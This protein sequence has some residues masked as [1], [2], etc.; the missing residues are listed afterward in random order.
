MNF[1]SPLF[2]FFLLVFLL[3]RWVLFPIFLIL[4]DSISSFFSK[5]QDSARWFDFLKKESW[6]ANPI[7]VVILLAGSYLFY[8]SWNCKFLALLIFTS[9]SDFLIGKKIYQSEEDRKRKIF[10]ILSISLNL[11]ILGFFKY[12][13]FFSQNVSDISSILG[14]TMSRPSWSI[15][16]PAGISFYTF[17]SLSYT[18]D[19]YR[20]VLPAEKNFFR[21]ALFLAFFPQLVAGPIVVAYDFLPQILTIYKKKFAEI[22]FNQAFYFILLG[23]IKKSVIADNISI[24]SDFVFSNPDQVKVLSWTYILMGMVSYSVQIYG[25][26]SGYTDIARGVAILFG[27]HLPENF[28]LPYFASSLTDFWRRWHI[29]LSSWLR[30]YLY[31]PLGGNRFGELMTYRN[32]FIT[33]LLGGLWH[34]ASWNFVI[35]G[36]FHGIYLGLE[37]FINSKIRIVPYFSD[38]RPFLKKLWKAI[39]AIFTFSL[40]TCLWVFFRS[41][42]LETTYLIFKGLFNLQVGILPNYS[43]EIQFFAIFILV[44]F[45]H[46][47]GYFQEDKIHKYLENDSSNWQFSIYAILSILA[48]LYSGELKPFIYFVF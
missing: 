4:I 20:K 2:L 18:I 9:F 24:I 46:F 14:F 15:L 10:L 3:I 27:F 17:Q 48:V 37:R 28:N 33:M 5:K 8:A 32:L 42:N 6:F 13:Y 16:L 43:V 47:I 34:G 39:Y 41:P 12:F 30:S 26:F 38:V 21:Y 7:L 1:V 23:F 45:S 36:A 25:D 11:S 35:W 31:I 40:V 29:S 44:L 19:V 22:N